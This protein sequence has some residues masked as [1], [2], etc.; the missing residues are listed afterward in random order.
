MDYLS[1]IMIAVL[2]TSYITLL[3]GN[4]LPLNIDN[5]ISPYKCLRIIT[6]FPIYECMY[7]KA[8]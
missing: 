2:I 5:N 1:Y 7:D 6:F 3:V 8:I 4:C